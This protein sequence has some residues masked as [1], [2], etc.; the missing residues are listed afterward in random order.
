MPYFL[1]LVSGSRSTYLNSNAFDIFAIADFSRMEFKLRKYHYAKNTLVVLPQ[2]WPD[3]KFLTL[4]SHQTD[5]QTNQWTCKQSF[6]LFMSICSLSSLSKTLNISDFKM[7][8][9]HCARSWKIRRNPIKMK[10]LSSAWTTRGSQN[11]S[12]ICRGSPSEWLIDIWIFKV[13]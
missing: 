8:W 7:F 2:F 6:S 1:L 5:I 4:L 13:S 3:H 9:M 12:T 11:S 10:T